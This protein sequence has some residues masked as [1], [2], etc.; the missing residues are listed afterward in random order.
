MATKKEVQPN[1][2]TAVQAREKVTELQNEI[3]ALDKEKAKDIA[4]QKATQIKD[5]AT[6][7]VK[8]ASE[9]ATP[10]VEK[11]A[12]EVRKLASDTLKKLAESIED[13]STIEEKPKKSKNA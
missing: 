13:K 6:E 9:K 3:R 8:I 7:L 1:K 12:K 2:L 10:A 5:K 4:I 11:T